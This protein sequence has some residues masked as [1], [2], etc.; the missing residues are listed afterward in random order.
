[1][2]LKICRKQC[3]LLL[4]FCLVTVYAAL[5]SPVLAQ[6]TSAR[7][8]TISTEVAADESL[9]LSELAR[10]AVWPT[11]GVLP[12][13][14]GSEV[15]DNGFSGALTAEED[16]ASFAL[17]SAAIP[18]TPDPT[19]SYYRYALSTGENFPD[20]PKLGVWTDIYVLTTREFGPAGPF[21]GI[22][23]Y[24]LEKNKMLGG[25]RNVRAIKF[26]LEPGTTPYL[27]G[28][29]LLPPD[30]DGNRRPQAGIPAP[31]IGTMDDGGGY[32]A[33]FDGLNI[34]DLAVHWDAHPSA[35][36][37]LVAQ[38]PVA[39]FDSIFP[40]SPS[41]R[42]CIPQPGTSQKIDILSY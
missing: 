32:G 12:D 14:R 40:C 10:R 13:E 4:L 27:T 6:T 2:R 19:A 22:G 9:P 15:A 37:T 21:A 24:A 31:V 41:S 39:A 8:P 18:K 5:P 7:A 11:S 25:Q 26:L 33:P 36:F 23:V 28:D 20:Y 3:T 38:L 1:M 35:S 16:A 42:S 29:G 17:T 30:I 34:F